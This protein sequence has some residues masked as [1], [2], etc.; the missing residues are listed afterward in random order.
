MLIK[1]DEKIGFPSPALELT[2]KKSLNLPSQIQ[3]M[4]SPCFAKHKYL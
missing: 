4:K 1:N 3:T 2:H